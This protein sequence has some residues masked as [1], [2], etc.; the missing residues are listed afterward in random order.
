MNPLDILIQ[1]L[2]GIS[3]VIIG[4]LFG[5]IL[6]GYVTV[7]YVFP[8]AMRNPEIQE[9]L[10]LFRESKSYLRELLEN[11]KRKSGGESMPH[12]EEEEGDESLSETEE[13]E[14]DEGEE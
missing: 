13:S 11:Q 3:Q 6:T 1:W 4:F 7:K 2:L 10:S 9:A 12:P 14:W 8:L 5:S